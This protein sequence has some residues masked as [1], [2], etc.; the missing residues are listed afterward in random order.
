MYMNRYFASFALLLALSGCSSASSGGGNNNSTGASGKGSGTGNGSGGST[1][2]TSAA[3]KGGGD[4]F[5]CVNTGDINFNCPFNL[6]PLTGSCAPHGDCCY[7]TSNNTKLAKLGPD[8]PEVLEFR[9]NFVDII[10]HPMSIGL[11]DLVRSAK[12]RADVCAGEQCLLWRFTAPRKGGQVTAGMGEVEIGIGAYNCDGTY[13]YYGPGAA[14]NR[15][16]EVGESDPGRWQAVKVP[17]AVDPTKDGVDRFHIPWATNRNREIARSIFIWPA[18]YTIDWE[19]ASSGFNITKFDWSEAGQDCQGSRPNGH[20]WSTV[21]GFVAYSPIKGNDKDISNQTNQTYCSLLAYGL[22]PEG[23]K[24]K[25]CDIERCMPDGGVF[26]DGGCDWLKLPD[27]LCPDNDDE[28]KIFGCHLGA[29]GNVNKE[30]GYP[31]MLSCSQDKPTAA[32]D[33]DMG[34]SSEGQC[35]DPLGKSSALPTCNAYRTVGKFVAA[36]AEITDKPIDKLPPMCH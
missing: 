6:P 22:L 4:Q 35:C 30:D 24:N 23:K 34:A 27:S 20:D 32:L 2:S 21:D 9:L 12:Q 1:M 3:G 36:A 14:P 31:A 17:A 8:D 25:A 15:T 16:S 19:L 11:P 18:D 5:S 10:N 13:S 7:R 29:E 33:P 28:R 26:G